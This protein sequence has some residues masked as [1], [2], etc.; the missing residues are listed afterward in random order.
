[1]E[2]LK[3]QKLPKQLLP[4]PLLLLHLKRNSSSFSK[5]FKKGRNT[6]VTLFLGQLIMHERHYLSHFLAAQG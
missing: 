2:K 5:S 6:F 1:V 3:Q 4:Q